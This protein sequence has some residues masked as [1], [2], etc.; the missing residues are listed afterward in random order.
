MWKLAVIEVNGQTLT[1]RTPEAAEEAFINGQLESDT[2]IFMRDDSGRLNPRPMN[3]IAQFRDLLELD[4][5]VSS[6]AAGAKEPLEAI[7]GSGDEAAEEIR[8]SRTDG[9][10][11][12][13][14]ETTQLAPDSRKPAGA[15]SEL[16]K[17]P[18]EEPVAAVALSETSGAAP[19]ASSSGTP[20]APLSALA[21]AP[22]NKEVGGAVDP[23]DE[24]SSEGAGTPSSDA[25]TLAASAVGAGAAIP[26]EASSSLAIPPQPSLAA[27]ESVSAPDQSEPHPDEPALPE[28]TIEIASDVTELK[29]GAEESEE[30]PYAWTSSSEAARGSA[31][32]TVGPNMWL[33]GVIAI[34]VL[35]LAV[36]GYMQFS[37]SDGEEAAQPSSE[38]AVGQ[39]LTGFALIDA[40]VFGSPDPATVTDEKLLYGE[41][42][43]LLAV[44]ENPQWQRIESGPL[45]GRYVSSDLV[46]ATR[47][48][49]IDRTRAGKMRFA[50]AADVR[51]SS[52]LQSP[53]IRTFAPGQAVRIF[54]IFTGLDGGD[55]GLIEVGSGASLRPGYIALSN[56]VP[57]DDTETQA[58]ADAIVA[59]TQ[60]DSPIQARCASIA[61]GFDR[62]AC[63]YPDVARRENQLRNAYSSAERRFAS[64][65]QQILPYARFR[66]R[67]DACQTPICARNE[68]AKQI[69]LLNSFQPTVA[70]VQTVDRS[71]AAKPRNNPGE[72]IR[73]RDYPKA[74][75]KENREGNVRFALSVDTGG[76]V[77]NCTVTRSSGHADLDEATCDAVKRRARF[78]PAREASGQAITGTFTS[79]V[80][81]RLP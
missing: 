69:E 42:V 73:S 43:N 68:I 64:A 28:D 2:L 23:A 36:L 38:V 74:A 30:L 1:L 24:P 14:V 79:S 76:R 60:A 10:E 53:V 56:N 77:S 22:I 20:T 11:A 25:E 61:N 16:M 13:P 81:W 40:P 49:A 8:P 54:G 50:M 35:M 57:L 37:G 18:V 55:W 17:T 41:Q 12:A 44:T 31:G 9:N 63:R 3:E 80:S 70:P 48:A 15:L 33:L 4:T 39:S 26:L 29:G 58:D 67:L 47:P 71:T 51:S 59:R 66:S 78:E 45:A 32:P 19:P 6:P 75:L 7:G 21:T 46:S 52:D 65:G 72:W 62:L 34:L 5:V 27:S